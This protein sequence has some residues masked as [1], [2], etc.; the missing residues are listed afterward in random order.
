M[1]NNSQQRKKIGN[2]TSNKIEVISTQHTQ[3]QK[4]TNYNKY[5]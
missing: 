1:V 4:L 5:I 3:L 2:R